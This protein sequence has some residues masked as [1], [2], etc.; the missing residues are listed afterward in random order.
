MELCFFSVSTGLTRILSFGFKHFLG[1]SLVRHRKSFLQ[2]NRKTGAKRIEVVAEKTRVLT[3]DYGRRG[4]G[5]G[6]L[7]EESGVNVTYVL[8]VSF[9]EEIP[10][11]AE[12]IIVPVQLLRP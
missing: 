8:F 11:S 12:P 1:C 6:R 5:E 2:M 4:G 3:G 10:P 7:E 9:H